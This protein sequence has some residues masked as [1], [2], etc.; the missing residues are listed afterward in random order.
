MP[1]KE[2]KRWSDV[3]IELLRKDLKRGIRGG[4]LYERHSQRTP[5]AVDKKVYQ[6]TQFW[7]TP[8]ETARRET[9]ARHNAAKALKVDWHTPSR[10]E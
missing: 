6:L 2:K 10:W 5:R 3:E 1:A 4:Q 9:L 8:Q 7:P